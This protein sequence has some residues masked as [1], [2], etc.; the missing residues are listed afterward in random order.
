MASEPCKHTHYKHELKSQLVNSKVI[1]VERLFFLLTIACSDCGAPYVF[2]APV[3]FSSVE[4]MADELQV[5]LRI[6]VE[7]P[8]QLLIDKEEDA[9]EDKEE[10]KEDETPPTLH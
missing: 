6:P 5:N 2:R 7:R 9:S 3:G 8:E 10:S 4:P 1:G